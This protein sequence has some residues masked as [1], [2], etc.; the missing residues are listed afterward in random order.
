MRLELTN[1]ALSAPR[2]TTELTDQM[3]VIVRIFIYRCE[4]Q[5]GFV[6]CS[7]SFREIAGGESSTY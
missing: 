3:L 6:F 7:Q 4:L 2:S 1:L 5:E